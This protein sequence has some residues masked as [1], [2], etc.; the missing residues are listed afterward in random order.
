MGFTVILLLACLALTGLAVIAFRSGRK[1][2][3]SLALAVMAVGTAELG[4]LCVKSPLCDVF[5]C[6]IKAAPS[7]NSSGRTK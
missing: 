1:A 7:H 2:L 3:G 4:Y 6:K 5:G